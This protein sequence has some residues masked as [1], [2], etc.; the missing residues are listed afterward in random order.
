MRVAD[1]RSEM[2]L[3]INPEHLGALRLTV[4]SDQNGVAAR[5]VVET[6]QAHHAVESARDQ[7]RSAL[8]HRGLSLTS[9]DVSLHHGGSGDTAFARQQQANGEAVARPGP[10]PAAA[11]GRQAEPV[12]ATALPIAPTGNGGRRLDTRM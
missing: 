12:A 8:E 9:L 6:S 4:T 2:T 7:L 3:R 10:R 1:G 5:I 11:D